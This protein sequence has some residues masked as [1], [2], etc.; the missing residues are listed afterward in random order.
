MSEHV[1]DIKAII[2]LGNP[3]PRFSRTHHNIGFMVVD[4]LASRYGGSWQ[5][6]DESEVADIRIG[7]KAVMLVKPQTFM[8]SSGRIVPMLKKKGITPD[9]TLVVHDEID[10]PFAKIGHKTGGSHRGHNGIRSLIDSWA[11]DFHRLRLG[12][13]R[14]ERKEDV[15]DYVLQKFTQSPELVQELIDSAAEIIEGLFEA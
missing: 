5:K 8:N 9:Q 11:A 13:G 3:G 10:F 4:A 12:V 2:G 1:K 15:P 7:D 6:K 14:P